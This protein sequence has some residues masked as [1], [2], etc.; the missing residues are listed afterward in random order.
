M[1]NETDW[2]ELSDEYTEH[3]PAI[4]GETI[5]PQRAIT[6]DDIDDI[7]AGRPLADQP[8]RKADVLYK[9]YLTPDMDA[10]VRAQ[11]ER[12]HIGKSALIRKALAA[13]LT[14]NQA[15]MCL[16]VCRGWC[17]NGAREEGCPVRVRRGRVA[18]R[19][20]CRLCGVRFRGSGRLLGLG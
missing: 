18:V 20:G 19:A 17:A 10:Q 4:I 7:F 11:A 12:E 9:A 1:S 5:R 6:M 15:L 3:T 13:Y 16:I 2:D 14:A 8:R